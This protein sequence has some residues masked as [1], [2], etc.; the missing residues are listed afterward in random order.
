MATVRRVRG[1]SEV[2]AAR[3]LTDRSWLDTYPPL[4]GAAQTSDIIRDRHSSARFARNAG[5][6]SGIFLV[7]LEGAKVVGHLYA[8]PEAGTYVDRL[9]VDP[10]ARGRGIGALLLA[11][12]R[13]LL[14]SRTRLWLTVLDGNE[15]ARRF[16]VREGFSLGASVDGLAGVRATVCECTVP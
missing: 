6:G 15:G 16:Y 14:P 13:T 12:L 10:D 4:I 5:D 9:H 8:V 2:E 1:K 3:R 7:A 11:H